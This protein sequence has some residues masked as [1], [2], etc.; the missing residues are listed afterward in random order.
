[1]DAWFCGF[2]PQLA[3]CVW[4]GY[5]KGEIPLSYVEG[6]AGVT[7]GTLPAEIWHAFMSQ[8]TAKMPIQY[9]HSPVIGGCT[10]SAPSTSYSYTPTYTT[11]YTSTTA[12][13][14]RPAPPPVS[15]HTPHTTPKPPPPPPPPAPPPTTTEPAPPPPPP[16]TT[17]GENGQ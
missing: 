12:A 10:V 6:V 9:F 8:A 2:V 3:T 15:E 1:V 4:I 13:P 11:T 7:G 14:S 5:P 17:I 16:T